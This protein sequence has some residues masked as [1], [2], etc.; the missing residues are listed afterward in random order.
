M[1]FSLLSSSVVVVEEV[2][3]K[4]FVQMVPS[5]VPVVIEV[6]G[7]GYQQADQPEVK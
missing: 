2:F 3:E 4:G 1:F 6:D 5:M 7:E